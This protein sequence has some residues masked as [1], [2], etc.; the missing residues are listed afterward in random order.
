MK[1]AGT[2]VRRTWGEARPALEGACVGCREMW[3]RD[4]NNPKQDSLSNIPEYSLQ[5]NLY[6][7]TYHSLSILCLKPREGKPLQVYTK[8]ESAA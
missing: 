6:P 3:H 1:A 2:S 5:P 8:W 7:E 4:K